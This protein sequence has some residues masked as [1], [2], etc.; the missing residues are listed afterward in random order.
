MSTITDSTGRPSTVPWPLSDAF[1]STAASRVATRSDST[2]S[3]TGPWGMTFT[4]SPERTM[5][6]APGVVNDP[7]VTARPRVD[8][9]SAP[10]RV[11]STSTEVVSRRPV[12]V[13]SPAAASAVSTGGSAG[14]SAPA[15]TPEM[16]LRLPA[17]ASA[18]SRS[19]PGRRIGLSVKLARKSGRHLSAT[20]AV[21]TEKTMSPYSSTTK[22]RSARST[23]RSAGAPRT[24]KSLTGAASSCMPKPVPGTAA[25]GSSHPTLPVSSSVNHTL[26]RWSTATLWGPEVATIVRPF[27]PTTAIGMALGTWKRSTVALAVRRPGSGVSR[28]MAL[29]SPLVNHTAP[30]AARASPF[31]SPQLHGKS[32]LSSSVPVGDTRMTPMPSAPISLYQ[33][34]VL[35][36]PSIIVAIWAGIRLGGDGTGGGGTG[37]GAGGQTRPTLHGASGRVV[38]PSLV[39]GATLAGSMRVMPLPSASVTQTIPWPSTTTSCG[40]STAGGIVSAFP[41]LGS[42]NRSI[43][44]AL[45]SAAGDTRATASAPSSATQTSPWASAAEWPGAD[46]E[47][48][49]ATVWR[50]GPRSTGRKAADWSPRSGSPRTRPKEVGDGRSENVL[51]APGG[52][53]PGAPRAS[54]A[55]R[56]APQS[57]APCTGVRSC[58]SV[59]AK[60][61]PKPSALV[62]V[63]VRGDPGGRLTA[64]VDR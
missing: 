27:T 56:K 47:G 46:Q 31:G 10:F 40:W 51:E 20:P 29:L 25:A 18:N 4:R 17:P 30:S 44:E 33:S 57:R 41:E 28:P 54:V 58:R 62:T 24:P 2:G 22:T 11:I 12:P 50:A 36:A 35:P 5:P 43:L 59:A 48:P 19:P 34:T 9:T 55:V 37:G 14:A 16:R 52:S 39:P 61:W 21:V 15:L 32:A 1:P 60:V 45:R 6:A 64:D 13:T 63:T 53:V 42:G 8:D 38:M 23:T 49:R 7:P 26:P 3:G